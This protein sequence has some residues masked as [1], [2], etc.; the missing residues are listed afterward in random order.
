[1]RLL[2]AVFLLTTPVQPWYA[3]LLLALVVLT[4]DWW[5]VPMA[6]AAYPLF[7]ATILDGPA[8]TVGRLSYGVAGLVALAATALRRQRGVPAPLTGAE[9]PSAG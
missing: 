1:M 6:A 3:L 7:F 9:L 2:V 5:A 8:V 4:G